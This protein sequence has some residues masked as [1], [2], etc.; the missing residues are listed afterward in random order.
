MVVDRHLFWTE[1]N[2]HTLEISKT[3]MEDSAVYCAIAHNEHGSVTCRCNLVVDKGIRAYIAPIFYCSFEKEEI[4]LLEGEEL[5]LNAQ[6][7][8]YPTVGVMWYRDGV[9]LF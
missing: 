6:I 4:S 3:R 7:E 5:R 1:D 2:F 8:A 9:S